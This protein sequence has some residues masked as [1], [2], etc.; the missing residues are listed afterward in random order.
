[1]RAGVPTVSIVETGFMGQARAIAKGLGI[2][3]APIAEYP[4]QIATDN[5]DSI[6]E[7]LQTVVI[8]QIERCL[9]AETQAAQGA[10]EPTS[11]DVVCQGTLE[12][13]NDYFYE[14][15]WTDGLPIVPPTREQVAEFLAFTRRSAD[16][17]LGILLPEK[18]KATIRNVAVNGVMAGC[19]PAYMPILIAIVECLA[20]PDY[21][22]EDSGSTPGWEPLV[23]VHGPM[24]KTLD[25]NSEA[26]AARPGRRS[27]TAIGRFVS[28]YMRNVAGLRPGGTSKGTF[29]ANFN[30]AL[31]E[32][33]GACERI[34][35]LPLGA[36]SY[37]LRADDNVVTVRSVVST[38]GPLYSGGD[39]AESHLNQIAEFIGENTSVLWPL[40]T[41]LLYGKWSPLIA[42]SPL[43]ANVI[44]R[45][46]LS[47]ADVR[48]HLF[49]RCR[50]R[51]GVLERYANNSGL[52][53]NR[54]NQRRWRL[55]DEAKAGRVPEAYGLSDDPER[56][57]PVFT[58]PASIQIIVAGDPARNQSRAYFNNHCQGM[59]VART[60]AEAPK[61]K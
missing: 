29:G 61:E 14:R 60:I 6:H 31:A 4:G 36:D 34:G 7:K 13:I 8:D 41:A 42:I 5:I 38:V 48:R 54:P 15:G 30:V 46:G 47:K 44:A 32:N 16:E 37:G 49:T 35:W 18:R 19:L 43:I 50:V 53:G 25:F 11:G 52:N 57:I 56:L 3:N 45:D 28:L 51:A 59:P 9:V 58:D 23:T 22:I 21:R 10:V 26:G 24:V 2:A 33:M 12:E 27:N 55:V 17:V 20:D 1:M 40:Y 39:K